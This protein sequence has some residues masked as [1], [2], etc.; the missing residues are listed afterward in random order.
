[1]NLGSYTCRGVEPPEPGVLAQVRVAHLC[2]AGVSNAAPTGTVAKEA[3]AH[4]PCSLQG[5]VGEARAVVP[6]F[7]ILTQ[8]NT[9]LQ[10]VT[11]VYRRPGCCLF[12]RK[13]KWVPSPRPQPSPPGPIFLFS[14]KKDSGAAEVTHGTHGPRITQT[15]LTTIPTHTHNC[16]SRRQAGHI[17]RFASYIQQDGVRGRVHYPLEVPVSR[18]VTRIHQGFR[19]LQ[20]L[21]R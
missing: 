18:T 4:C 21:D 19:H 10:I 2:A 20:K 6:V 15:N 17:R 12:H 14:Q 11:Q 5:D 9:S 1:M 8:S 13:E 16:L 3:S 7:K